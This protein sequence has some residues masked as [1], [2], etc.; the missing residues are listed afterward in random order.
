MKTIQYRSKS[1]SYA[2]IALCMDHALLRPEL[3]SWEVL[4][5]CA[6]AKRYEIG[7]VSVKPCY[8][9]PAYHSLSGCNVRI[10][11]VIGFPHGSSTAAVKTYE[12]LEAVDHGA[13][14]LDI[15]INYGALRS[16]ETQVIYEELEQIV[17]AVN[18]RALIKVILETCYLTKAQKIL[19]C[20]IVEKIGGDFVKTSSGY[21]AK[22]ATIADVRLMKSTVGTQLQVK[23]AGKIRTL[24]QVIRFLDA[25]CSRIGTSATQSILDEFMNA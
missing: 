8:L 6:M 11:T 20:Q 16:G 18:H 7:A 22:G 5:G 21:T 9:K 2:D 19:A 1:Y 4:D 12:A 13:Q 14:E 24:R 15:V 10:G 3:T 17:A 23:A 25:G